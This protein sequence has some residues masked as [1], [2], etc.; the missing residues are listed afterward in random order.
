MTLSDYR[1]HASVAVSD[2]DRAVEFY[3]GKLDLPME[4]EQSDGSRIYRSGGIDALHVFPSPSA[5]HAVATVATWH[6]ADLERSVAE[7]AARGVPFTH[8][9]EPPLQTDDRGILLDGTVAWFTDPDG[10]TFALEQQP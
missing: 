3:E 8:Y 10:N 4:R 1:L 5:G 6:V 7:L 9:D 2:M